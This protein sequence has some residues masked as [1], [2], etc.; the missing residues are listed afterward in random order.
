M[1][2]ALK[3]HDLKVTDQLAR[4][5]NARHEMQARTLSALLKMQNLK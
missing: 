2:E 4:R 3:M 1:G 5:E